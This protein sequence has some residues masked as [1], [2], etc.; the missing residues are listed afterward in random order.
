MIIFWL[1]SGTSIDS[2]KFSGKM[3]YFQIY[4]NWVLVR[5]LVPCY[6]KSDSVIG[7]YDL[8][9]NQF[10]TNSWTG[11]FTKWAD[12]TAIPLKNA[13]IGE[14]YEYSYDFRSKTTSQITSDG[15]SYS[16]WGTPSFNSYGVYWSWIRIT[17]NLSL[18]DARKITIT[19]YWTLN[20]S[21]SFSGYIAK[22]VTSQTRDGLSW[23]S[24]TTEQ[25]KMA[26]II[27][28]TSHEYSWFSSWTYT[29]VGVI[30]FVAKTWTLSA[31]W[32]TTQTWT[33]TDTDVS[34]IKNNTTKLFA[35]I[36]GGGSSYWLATISI[37]VEK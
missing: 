37:A 26:M 24:I 19:T 35:Y 34:N 21:A 17:R 16:A 30:D 10:Y 18:T 9:N 2:R 25:N 23:T 6:R 12:V 27:Y 20:S 3:W 8:V 28:W 13:Y 32:K 33:L 29:V 7:L 1:R 11:T 5:D 22:T 14:V 4:D 31:T 36:S 15:W